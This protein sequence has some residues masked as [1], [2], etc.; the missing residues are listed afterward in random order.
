MLEDRRR[1]RKIFIRL[2]K[3][4]E[5]R[6][7]PY[8]EKA[9]TLYLLSGPQTNRIGL[10]QVSFG[11]ASEDLGE[12]APVLRKRLEKVVAA[13]GWHFDSHA[14]V[15]WIPSWWDFNSPTGNEN[16][17]KG[18]L[19]DL[20]EVP[21]TPLI[22]RFASHLTH[23]PPGLHKYFQFVLDRYTARTPSEHRSDTVRTQEQDIEQ[24]QEQKQEQQQET[25]LARV[26]A[27]E[28]AFEIFRNAYPA[29]RRVG[30]NEGRR[31]FRGA[32]K[33]RDVSAHLTVMLAALEQHQRSEQ[34][35]NPKYI[36]LMTTWLN[37]ERWTMQL[38]ESSPMGQSVKTVGNQAAL[39]RFVARRQGGEA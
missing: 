23:V 5:F 33:G 29:A 16:N 8:P 26:S 36:P 7:L 9:M 18:A 34:W 10:F 3:N 31:A 15:L 39:E 22:S 20:A 2:W 6:A 30:G 12:S 1:Y 4:A 35:Q 38:P 19:S 28:S 25:A 27:S 24:E 11:A 17:T 32:L 37:Q 13:F 21:H 14:N